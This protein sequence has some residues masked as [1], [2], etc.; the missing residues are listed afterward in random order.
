M[1]RV[2]IVTITGG[3]NYGNK[4]QHYAVLRSI[5]KIGYEPITIKDS[6]VKGFADVA[7]PIPFHAKISM[8][9]IKAVINSRMQYKYNKKNESDGFLKCIL[10]ERKNHDVYVKLKEER[11]RRFDAFAEQCLP[12]GELEVNVSRKVDEAKVNQFHAFVCGSDQVW[13]PRYQDVSPMRFLTFA[14]KE[15]RIALSPSFGVAEI[16][17][18]RRDIY[19]KMLQEFA[20][21]SVRE[22][23]GARIVLELTGR[24]VPVLI[25]PTLSMS[26]E[27]WDAIAKKP[28]HVPERAFLLTYFL[29]NKDKKCEKTICDL[30]KKRNLIIVDLAELAKSEYYLY[31]PAEFVWLIKHAS[32]VCTDSFHGTVFSIIYHKEFSVFFRN[33]SGFSRDNRVITLLKKLELQDALWNGERHKKL[34]Y[35]K[36][37]RCLDKERK[38]YQEYLRGSLDNIDDVTTERDCIYQDVEQWNK[39]DKYHCTGC[40]GCQHICPIQ[41]IEMKKNEE[42]FTYPIVNPQTCVHC[43]KCVS[44]C[45]SCSKDGQSSYPKAY[46]VT[47]KKEEIRK[48]SSSGGV[49]WLLAEQIIKESGVVFGASFVQNYQLQHCYA[50]TMAEVKKFMG[51]KYLQSD[52]E[53]SFAKVKEFL[54]QG[55]KV[56][57]TGT[58]CQVAALQRF[59][60]EHSLLYTAD[61]ICH[62]VPSQKAFDCYLSEKVG[63]DAV[64][65][66]SFRDKTM[67]WAKFS[68]LIKSGN[69]TYRQNLYHD[70]YLRAF[71]HNV[72]LRYSCYDCRFKTAKHASDITMADLWG[73]S[74][75]GISN[76]DD[77]G[78]SLVLVQSNKGAKLLEI[79]QADADCQQIDAEKAIKRNSAALN[80]V[81]EPKARKDFYNQISQ[82][83]FQR[84]V[85]ELLPITVS[86]CIGFL[87]EDVYKLIHRIGIK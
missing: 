31:D 63:D 75:L 67:G 66:V 49:F 38:Q 85:E 61:F 50:E 58:P 44:Y 30:A 15:K 21:L 78:V 55:R 29:G 51:S 71:L 76:E 57:F 9:Y 5:E 2:G 6:T 26:A 19:K 84:V 60:G 48:T 42:G 46:A 68:M 18:T 7:Y 40:G 12:Y 16:P 65:Q 74:S 59:I 11:K 10:R 73:A 36:A 53:N 8:D 62:G 39:K 77:K 86:Q 27:E 28:E 35:Y 1:K 17:E 56:L 14:P 34:D 69:K 3:D 64:E 79:I 87:K 45:E 70:S 82:G 23:S 54:N 47:N 20:Y 81:L 37:D 13:N 83:S 52:T 24:E 25:D 22:E 80:S 72:N 32:Y 43:K 33:E 4:L 41:A